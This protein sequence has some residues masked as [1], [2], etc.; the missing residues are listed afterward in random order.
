MPSLHANPVRTDIV[1]WNQ[2]PG[3]RGEL[4][5]EFVINRMRRGDASEYIRSVVRSRD[6]LDWLKPTPD[7]WLLDLDKVNAPFPGLL[8]NEPWAKGVHAVTP[9]VRDEEVLTDKWVTIVGF[10]VTEDQTQNAIAAPMRDQ[11]MTKRV[12]IGH[13]RSSLWR[14]L[15]DFLH[16]RLHLDF[17]EFNRESAAGL[18]TKERLLQMLDAS[19]FAFLLMTAEDQRADGSMTARANV[20]HEVGLFQGRLGFEHLNAR[21]CSSR[22]AARNSPILSA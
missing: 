16:E 2:S 21:L 3:H 13:G 6:D 10:C 18:S 5:V 11:R 22:K 14:D 4:E 17:E 19:S 15:K 1:G 12:F 20:I 7:Q 9:D 8:A